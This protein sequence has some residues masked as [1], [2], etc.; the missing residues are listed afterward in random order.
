M[1]IQA[2]L[3]TM[4]G[5]YETYK[6]TNY[7]F[8]VMGVQL[9]NG[10]VEQHFI[11]FWKSARPTTGDVVGAVTDYGL[12]YWYLPKLVDVVKIN[13]YGDLFFNVSE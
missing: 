8:P 1:G 4:Y 13:R 10:I 5:T 7:T 12:K 2:N 6:H 9:I 11:N 3:W